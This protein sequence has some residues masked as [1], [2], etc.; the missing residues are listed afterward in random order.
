MFLHDPHLY[1]LTLPYKDLW[2]RELY[3]QIPQIPYS[4]QNPYQVPFRD[5][6]LGCTPFQWQN[7]PFQWQNF[8]R[9]TPP[10]AVPPTFMNFPVQTPHQ[11]P[12][13]IPFVGSQFP[14]VPMTPSAINQPWNFGWQRPL[15]Y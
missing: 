7:T 5:V 6:N 15:V 10:F 14:M 1:G 4:Y 13:N 2:A 9:F 11:Y 3:G 8:Q 12:M